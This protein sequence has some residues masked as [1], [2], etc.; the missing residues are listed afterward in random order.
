M[1]LISTTWLICILLASV[2]SHAGESAFYKLRRIETLPLAE[3]Q[4]AV[5]GFLALIPENPF[6]KLGCDSLAIIYRGPGKDVRIAGDITDWK[7]T[8]QLKHV[9]GTDLWY[10]LFANAPHEAR[11]DYK[12]VCDGAWKLDSRNPLTCMSGFGPNSE[13]R[14]HAYRPPPFVRHKNPTPCHLDTLT[15]QTPQLGGQRTVVVLTP[16]G[17]D[18]PD[19]PYLLVHDGLEYLTLA[20]LAKAISWF[21]TY[22]SDLTLPICIC[23][24]PGRRTE[25]YA[26]SLQDE[27][28]R[29][30]TD[31]LM[32]LIEKRYGERGPWGSMGAS[33]GGEISLYL[34]RRYPEQFDRVAVMSPAVASAQHHGITKLEPSSLKLYVN[35]GIYDIQRLIP[36]C[37]SFVRM[38]E[39]KGFDPL[40][41]VKPQGHSW[42][43]WRDSLS[44][45]LNFL[46]STSP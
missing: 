20:D 23:V 1:V 24:P 8:L 2:A 4:A 29:F 3:R 37:E 13:L 25:E 41:E 35:W 34:A 40:V 31:T 33:Y 15:V 7:P 21:Q 9:P 36:G 30:V 16:P 5:D 32:H 14:L 42:G 44:P 10:H 43:F 18:D 12:F 28:G 6:C 11:L 22:R 45:A 46:Y 39:E 38:L 26:T 19:R 17:L 27:F